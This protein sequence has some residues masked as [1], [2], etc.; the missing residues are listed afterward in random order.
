MPERILIT[1][2]TGFVGGWLAEACQRAY[3]QAALF[4]L[5]HPLATGDHQPSALSPARAPAPAMPLTHIEADI[6]DAGQV[7]AAIAQARPDL[8]FHLAGQASVAASW[9]DPARTLAVNAG[10]A[11][12]LFEVL[13]A[14][15]LLATRVV[16]AGSGEQY[17]NVAEQENP[18]GEE[19]PFRPATPYAVSKAAQDLYGY[20]YGAAWHLPVLRARSFNAFGPRGGSA[21]VIGDFARQIARL[22]AGAGEPVLWV[23]NLAARR[24]FLPVQDVVA[25]Y[26]ALAERGR[27]GEAYNI[28][29]GH[30]HSIEEVLRALVGLARVEIAVRPDPARFRPVDVP[31]LVAD[32]TKLRRETGWQ[33]GYDFARA[34]EETLEY[35]RLVVRQS[36]AANAA[37]DVAAGA[38]GAG[39]G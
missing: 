9:A 38:E 36:V 32:T 19:T 28:G 16:L 31:L 37:A 2:A 25:A 11:V 35:W 8:I 5:G 20:Q 24:D 22:E 30:G 7:R 18:I 1:G 17:G 34:L 29:S 23:G 26:L 6:T 14:E 15:G 21:F 10:G 13:R 12:R 27:P 39:G 33:P 3:P 4:G